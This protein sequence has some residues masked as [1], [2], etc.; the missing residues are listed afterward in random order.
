MNKK[1]ILTALL[2]VAMA[3]KAKTFNWK[4]EGSFL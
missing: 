3:G 2:L 1:T 4:I